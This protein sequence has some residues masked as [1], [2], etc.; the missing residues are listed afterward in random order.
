MET[1]DADSLYSRGISHIN[2]GT[3]EDITI[4]DL[5]L[6]IKDIVDFKGKIVHDLNKPDGMPKKLLDVSRLNVYGWKYKIGLE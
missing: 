6:M 4:K 1:I 5:A 3:G 2:V